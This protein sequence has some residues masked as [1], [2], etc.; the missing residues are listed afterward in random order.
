MGE[1]MGDFRNNVLRPLGQMAE[2]RWAN[3]P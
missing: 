2:T 1:G 3:T